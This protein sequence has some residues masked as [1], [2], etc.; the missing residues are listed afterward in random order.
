[1]GDLFRYMK[2]EEDKYVCVQ[3]NEFFMKRFDFEL[4]GIILKLKKENWFEACFL[5]NSDEKILNGIK[6]LWNKIK[7]VMMIFQ[8][9]RKKKH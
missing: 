8:C 7:K 1:M 3:N 9:R 4:E 2:V 5:I 6:S